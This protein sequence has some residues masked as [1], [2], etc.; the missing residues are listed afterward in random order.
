MGRTSYGERWM[1]L[2]AV[3]VLGCASGTGTVDDGLTDQDTDGSESS[4]ADGRPDDPT[5]GMPPS[6][7]TGT[8]GDDCEPGLAGCPCPAMAPCE[9][10]LVCEDDTC[11]P[12]TATCGDGIVSGTEQCDDGNAEDTDACTSSC[13]VATC[14]DAIVQAGVED[15]DDGNTDEGDGCSSSCT[16]RL[17]FEDGSQIAGWQ[18]EGG[19]GRYGEAPASDWAAVPFVMQGQ[20]FGTDGNRTTAAPGAEHESSSATTTNFVIPQV[21]RFRSWH[22]DEGGPSYDTKRILVSV[23]DGTRWESLVDC[24]E[25]PHSELPFC[26][27]EKGPRGGS[28]WDD[29]EIDASAFAGSTGMLRFEYDT[30][31]ECCGFEQGW[32]ID[33]LNALDCS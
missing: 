23:D 11:V 25:G 6:P 14:G 8:T 28:E 27:S 26:L 1:A 20:V 17:N 22:V 12:P 31:D 15:C 9:D 24:N 7:M 2:L 3:T 16:C 5:T 10:G 33:D 4:E 30:V 13:L 29:I 32:F 19:W 21:L 18:L